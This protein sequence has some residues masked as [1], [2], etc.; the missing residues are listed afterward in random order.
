M[1]SSACLYCPPNSRLRLLATF[2]SRRNFMTGSQP[3]GA[4]NTP[5]PSTPGQESDLP[6]N[7]FPEFVRDPL[8]FL[9]R[10]WKQLGDVAEIHFGPRPNFLVV[11][12][13]GVKQV[14][15]N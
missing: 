15:Q 11:H 3:V 14:L 7:D 2:S 8:G 6:L 4:P 12:P 9:R 13:D 5:S 1:V 10:K